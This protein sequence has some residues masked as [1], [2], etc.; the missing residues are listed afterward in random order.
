MVLEAA[1][2]STLETHYGNII[3]P[4]DLKMEKTGHPEAPK[5]AITDI[6]V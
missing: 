3:Q 5:I 6:G 1:S 4:P 2:K